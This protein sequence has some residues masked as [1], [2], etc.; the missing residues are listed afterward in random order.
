MAAAVPVA[1]AVLAAAAVPVAAVVLAAAAALVVVARIPAAMAAAVL[2]LV[3]LIQPIRIRARAAVG[4]GVVAGA[5][6]AAVPARKAHRLMT[7][8]LPPAA[9]RLMTARLPAAARRRSDPFPMQHGQR[10]HSAALP[11]VSP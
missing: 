5:A 7:A 2:V 10:R 9:R 11:F 6:D 3:A 4:A 1:A 8:R